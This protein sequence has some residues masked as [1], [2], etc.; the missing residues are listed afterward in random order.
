MPL[1]FDMLAGLC[2]FLLCFRAA[3][4][5]RMMFGLFAL[6]KKLA[7]WFKLARAYAGVC[8]VSRVSPET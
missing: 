3:V 6:V 5:G 2:Y 4:L 8:S 7:L 1:Q